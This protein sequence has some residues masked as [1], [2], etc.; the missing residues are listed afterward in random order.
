MELD[1]RSIERP[2]AWRRAASRGAWR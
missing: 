2:L 1:L